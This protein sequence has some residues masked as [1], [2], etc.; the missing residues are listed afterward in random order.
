MAWP[1]P[2][3]TKNQVNKA[4]AI[5]A[6]DEPDL[7]EH[8]SAYDVVNYWRSCHGYPINTFQATLR[9]KL[10]NIEASAIVAQR[11]KRM[12]SI[13]N[14]LHRLDGMQLVRMQDIGGLRAVV[15]TVKK[16]RELENNYRNS[17]FKH[18]LISSKDYIDQPKASGYRS[19]HMIYSYSNEKA[20]E[21]DGLLLELQIR[22]RIQHAWATAVETMGTFLDKALKSSEGPKAWLDFFSLTGSSFAHIERTT[23]VPGYEDLSKEETFVR[24]IRTVKELDVKDRLAAFSIAANHIHKEKG[25]GSY[26]LVIL[27]TEKKLVNVRSFGRGSLNT[28]SDEYGRIEKQIKDGQPLQAVLVSAGSLENLRRAYPNYFLDT[29]EFVRYLE[30]VEMELKK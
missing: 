3:H 11:L 29:R 24:T 20:P 9:S 6:Q 12:P 18:R 14:K 10:A 25:A 13:V 17:N 30:K 22:T 21:Y 5:L 16:V 27:D 26:H 7:F 15:T 8:F 1:V 19:V 23:P 28:A 4:G 2:R